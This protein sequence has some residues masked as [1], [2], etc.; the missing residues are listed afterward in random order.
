MT[1][2]HL[3][4]LPPAQRDILPRLAGALSES[5]MY[6]AGGTALALYCGHRLSVDFDWFTE[7]LGNPETLLQRLRDTGLHYTLLSQGRETIY[8]EIDAVQVSC[9]GYA[10][11]LL[12]PAHAFPELSL[13]MASLDDILCMKLSAVTNRGARKDF[14]DLHHA[15]THLRPLSHYLHAYT[16]KFN[17]RDIGHVIRSLVYFADADTEPDVVMTDPISWSTIKHDFE[18]WV[19]E[20]SADILSTH[21]GA[22]SMLNQRG[23]PAP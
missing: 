11:P 13:S 22:E 16:Q 14:V 12:E 9:I 23:R 3:D 7:H 20:L 10:Y 2:L 8:L 21:S 4:M 15:V 5:G 6:L 1:E 19:R 17:N 18:T